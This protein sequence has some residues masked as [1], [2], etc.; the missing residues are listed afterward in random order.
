M[1]FMIL[2]Q[3]HRRDGALGESGVPKGELPQILRMGMEPGGDWGG[4]DSGRAIGPVN[5]R[6]GFQRSTANAYVVASAPG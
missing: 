4:D 2:C 1:Q 6:T 3:R 5:F